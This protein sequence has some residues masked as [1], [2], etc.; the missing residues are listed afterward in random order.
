[1]PTRNISL[2]DRWDRF[3]DESVASGEYQN[4][5]EVVRHGLRL[6]VQQQREDAEKLMRLRSLGA[7]GFAEID[8][9]DY[10]TIAPGN[11][12]SF[13]SEMREEVSGRGR[14]RKRRRA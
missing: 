5:S 10:V 8:R 12:G 4:A 14:A 6:L 2:T 11:A 13:I 9:G 7:A 3:I 1:M